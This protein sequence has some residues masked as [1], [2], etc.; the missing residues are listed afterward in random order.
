MGWDAAF[1]TPKTLCKCLTLFCSLFLR[2]T[3]SLAPLIIEKCLGARQGTKQRATEVLLLMVEVDTSA[4]A[5]V[6]R[7]SSCVAFMSISPCGA[8]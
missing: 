3:A 2:Q 4:E 6:V 8:M 5:V 7:N 1:V